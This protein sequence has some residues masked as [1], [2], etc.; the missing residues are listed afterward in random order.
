MIGYKDMTFCAS[1]ES[2]ADGK[3]CHWALTDEVREGAR[4][5]WGDDEG[6]APISV[7]AGQKKCF[8]AKGK[9]DE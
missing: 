8:K 6:D 7:F 3:D 5:W 2:C 9:G 1:H 4:L